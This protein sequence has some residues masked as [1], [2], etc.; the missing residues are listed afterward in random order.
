MVYGKKTHYFLH[1]VHYQ[2]S[3]LTC[4]TGALFFLGAPAQKLGAPNFLIAL[5]LTPQFYI[6]MTEVNINFT[7]IS[8]QAESDPENPDAKLIDQLYQCGLSRT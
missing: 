2:G 7:T 8:I 1:T 5:H 3:T 4:F 6:Y